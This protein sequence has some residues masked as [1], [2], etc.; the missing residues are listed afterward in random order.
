[1]KE[2]IAEGD[3][4]EIKGVRLEVV[5]CDYEHGLYELRDLDIA[6]MDDHPAVVLTDGQI[7]EHLPS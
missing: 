4:I 7:Q 3:T 1:V 5:A 2:R 6:H